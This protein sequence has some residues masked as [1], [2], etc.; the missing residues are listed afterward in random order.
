MFLTREKCFDDL[1]LYYRWGRV[2]YKGQS[3]FSRYGGNLDEAK[4]EFS[5]KFHDKTRNHWAERDQ[6]E[7]V[8]GKYDLVKMDYSN[9]NTDRTTDEV[10]T[11]AKPRSSK[12]K[13][14]PAESK[15]PSSVQDLIR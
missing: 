1:P 4:S 15:L 3:N 14:E 6:F 5:K 7:K 10:D 13:D 9:S 8:A 2:G 12:V 11:K